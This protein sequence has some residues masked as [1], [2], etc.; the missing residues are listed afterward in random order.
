MKN[1]KISLLLFFALFSIS[2]SAQS[3]DE[4]YTGGMENAI[5]KMDTARTVRSIK[6]VRNQFDRIARKYSD[7]WL[8]VYYV[9]YNDL[10]MVYLNP[11]SEDNLNLLAE[12]KEKLNQLEKLKDVNKSELS[13]L[14][15]YYYSALIVTDPATNGAKYY[16]DVLSNYKQAIELNTDN[17]RPV[18]LLAFFEQNLPPFLQSGKDFCGELKKSELLYLKEKKL[19]SEI[20]W[21]KGLLATLL[22]K[23]Q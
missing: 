15:G 18:F 13:T 2:L 16:N 7:Q 20:R 14:W 8:P 23:C 11:Q 22:E 10:E 9:A 3:T 12:A 17:P 4:V 1:L 5:A 6:Q 19:M 21:G